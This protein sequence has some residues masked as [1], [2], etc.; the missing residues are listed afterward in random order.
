MGLSK[1]HIRERMKTMVIKV[2]GKE[3]NLEKE[4][5]IKELLVLQQIVMPDFVIV[6]V[7]D[8][9]VEQG[10]YN[11]VM[12]KDQDTIEFLFFMGGGSF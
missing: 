8:K 5:T 2:N 3:V 12:L 10:Q 9:F 11:E 1:S 4:V 7:N 6:Q